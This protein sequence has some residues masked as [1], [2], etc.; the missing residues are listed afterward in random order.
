MQTINIC[1]TQVFI[2]R[3]AGSFKGNWS[4]PSN[5][6]LY[7]TLSRF[8][9]WTQH[10][11]EGNLYLGD[12]FFVVTIVLGNRFSHNGKACLFPLKMWN[13]FQFVILFL[14]SCCPTFFPVYLCWFHEGLVW[15]TTCF[16]S[17]L[18]MSV[19]L[20][21][22]F[23]L[24][25]NILCPEHF[26]LGRR[27]RKQLNLFD[28]KW[29]LLILSHHISVIFKKIELCSKT[30]FMWSQWPLDIQQTSMWIFQKKKQYPPP[31]LYI[32]YPVNGTEWHPKMLML[33]DPP[34]AGTEAH[35]RWKNLPGSNGEGYEVQA[36][37]L[38]L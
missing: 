25:W 31:T 19:F 33:P 13:G 37:C 11:N 9:L 4:K 21:F 38:T 10:K 14:P 3:P 35:Y 26:L 18:C 28:I 30:C 22:A 29:F 1:R 32:L 8:I 34:V 20:F 17:F 24:R 27:E 15:I 23:C 2:F 5:C 12:Y 16:K 6:N 36:G 7:R